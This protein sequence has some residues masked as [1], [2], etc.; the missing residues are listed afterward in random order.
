MAEI[1]NFGFVRHLRAEPSSHII[2]YKDGRSH[3][4]GRG[5]SLWFLPM[6]T[7]LAEV[8][9]DDRELS[10]LFHGRTSDFQDVTTQGVITYRV[11][12]PEVTAER[13]D[14]SIDLK[15]GVHLEQPL[16][17]LALFLNELAQQFA[18]AY[19]VRT[20]VR[21]LLVSGREKV[22]QDIISGFEHESGLEALGIEIV[23]V[24]VSS[25]KPSADLE[26]A[27]ET[28]TREKIQQEADEAMFERRA[29]AVEKE[30]AIA[31][32]ELQNQIALATREEQLIAQQGQNERRRI[33]E[34]AEAKKIAAQAE[35]ERAQIQAHAKAE[36]I[37]L[38]E[39]ARVEGERER[40]E[41]YRDLPASVS[42]GLAARELAGKLEKIEHLNLSPD[43]L[44]PSL[45][46]L[47]NLG[48]KRLE[49]A[50]G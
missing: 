19:V 40:M 49:P 11:A 28:K 4:S 42:M 31:E 32:N 22:R 34:S 50:D 1:R 26:K 35:A 5:M 12:V 41:I 48:A 7:A 29:L 6:S 45:L 23:S 21:E 27:L 47:M 9:V 38:V 46:N 36:G 10:F 25:I 30:R 16:E 20:P 43:L 15:A 18:W 39:H 44:G 17:K 37:R 24:R 2:K 14:F 13:I 8:P 3:R 33:T